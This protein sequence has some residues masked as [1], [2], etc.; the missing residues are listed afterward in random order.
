MRCDG[1]IVEDKLKR[2]DKKKVQCS[3]STKN[4]DD[5]A[6]TSV[7]ICQCDEL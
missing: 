7:T 5:G 4:K 3:I 1:E 6:T 2:T